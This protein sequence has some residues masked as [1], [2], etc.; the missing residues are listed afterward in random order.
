MDCSL[1]CQANSVILEAIPEDGGM[2]HIVDF[3][4]GT[5]YSGPHSLRSLVGEAILW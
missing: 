2:V 4:S 3:A 5:E 1:R